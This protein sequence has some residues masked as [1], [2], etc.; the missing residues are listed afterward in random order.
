MFE[1]VIV[2]AMDVEAIFRHFN[3]RFS[4]CR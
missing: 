1:F 2:G 4:L 3:L